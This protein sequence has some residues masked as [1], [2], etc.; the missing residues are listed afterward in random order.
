M[1][2]ISCSFAKVKLEKDFL[3]FHLSGRCVQVLLLLLCT[4]HSEDGRSHRAV[5]HKVLKGR[6]EMACTSAV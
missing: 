2:I 1:M 6:G 5:F 3:C 4:F